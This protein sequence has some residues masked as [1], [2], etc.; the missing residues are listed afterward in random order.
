MAN[1][2][3]RC[4][5]AS[6]SGARADTTTAP[7][8]GCAN[9]S[10]ASDCSDPC[11]I[12]NIRPTSDTG[13]IS[14]LRSTSNPRPG[15]RWGS[16]GCDLSRRLALQ[17]DRQR[18]LFASRRRGLLVIRPGDS[19]SKRSVPGDNG[20]DARFYKSITPCPATR[21]ASGPHTSLAGPDLPGGGRLCGV[22]GSSPTASHEARSS[23]GRASSLGV[24]PWGAIFLLTSL[25]RSLAR[26]RQPPGSWCPHVRCAMPRDIVFSTMAC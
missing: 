9:R 20:R 11:P 25:T 22:V 5:G 13:S 12:P 3:L 2:S 26:S 4:A 10:G 21:A 24:I 14:D 8:S 16:H 1:T 19:E 23:I 18:R 7:N 17:R 15:N 6:S